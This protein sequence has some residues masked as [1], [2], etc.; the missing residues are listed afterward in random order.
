MKT[1]HLVALST[2]IGIA[3]AGVGM[4]DQA[5]MISSAQAGEA[6]SAP[7]VATDGVYIITYR[8]AGLLNYQGGVSGL[9]RTAPDSAAGQKLDRNSVAAHGYEAWLE[10]QRGVHRAE[11]ESAIGRVIRASHSYG[12]TFNGIAVELTPDEAAKVAALP[13]VES[14]RP[15]GVYHLG[16]YRGPK[17]I[18]AAQV[19]DG[20]STPS[21]VG[22]RGQGVKVGIID[23]GANSAHP[24]FANDATCGFS[25]SLPKLTAK[26]CSS[27]SG[28]ICN[29]ANPQ[30]NATYGHG[31]HTGSTVAGNTIDNTVTPAPSLPNGVTMS[32]VAPCAQVF[33]YKV[34]PTDSC[35]GADIQA[36]IDNAIADGVD[37][38]NFSISGGT[39]PWTDNDR[40]FLDAVGAGVFVAAA[41][42]NTS[43]SVTNP[44]GQVNHRGPWV[45]TVAATT[46][47]QIIGPGFSLTGP[48]TPP[49]L[50]QNVA[51]NPGSTTTASSTPTWTGKPVKTWPTNI[52]ACTASGGIPAGTFTGAI[53]VVRRGTCTFTEKITNAFNAGA[54]LVVIGN[55]Q[56]GSINMDTTGAPNVPAYS[57]SQAS[58]DA[59]IAFVGSN[60]SNSTADVAPIVVASRQG[61]VLANFSFRGPTPA[62]LADL[63]KPDISGPGVDIYAA[64]DPAS[65]QYQF[66][67]GT[68]M[69]TPHVA[70]AGALVKAVHPT[71][72]PVEIRS[73]LMMTAKPDGFREDGTTPWDV[74]DVGSGRVNVAAAAMAGLTMNETK[75]NFLAANP[76]GGSINVKQLNVPSLRNM[77]CAG[78][79]SW[80]RTVK[81]RMAASGNWTVTTTTD[82]SFSVSASPASFTLAANAEQ[83][84]TFTATPSTNITAVKFGYITLTEG[85]SAS[86]AQ[87]LTVAIKGT[88]GA[89]YTVGGSVSGLTGTGLVLK[90]NGANNLSVNANGSFTFPGGL[91]GGA[92]YAVTVGTQPSGQ[93]CSV[94]NGS[95]TIASTNVTNVAVTCAVASNYT[96]GGAVSGLTAAGLKLSLNTGAQLLDVPA[97]ATSYVFANP[98]ID[99]S[100]YNV[101]IVTQP[102]GL[103]CS[104]S[105]HSGTL[106]GANVTNVNISCVPTVVSYTV[107]G[108]IIGL[109]ANGLVLS[110]NAG[111]QTIAITSG[112]TAFTFPTGLANGAAYAVAV[113]TQPSGL[114]C[115]ATS[116]S[117]TIAGANVTNVVIDCTDRIFA[118]GFESP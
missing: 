108:S 102:T 49:V 63:T 55:N 13:S 52:E 91:A 40:K 99:G 64:T 28:G 39:S 27:S 73:A 41:A 109:S 103:T 72:S 80:T 18:G 101:G 85:S 71:W 56:A 51:L 116:S 20:T 44:V 97:N 67:S 62:P 79:C 96:I 26:D 74:D 8:E 30:A 53:A 84:I 19:W 65:G 14:V 117:G 12:I 11:I 31:V 16:T 34:C 89:T 57:T 1:L 24:S 10:T 21:H 25:V 22:T 54:E 82:P 90:L 23:G 93:T 106:A 46:Q 3:L 59:V 9:A 5:R 95:G 47:D 113:Q 68:S 76:S 81:N 4:G 104:V 43:A 69:A 88:S 86:P 75:A 35:P 32:G 2:A 111:A 48:G 98:I 45:M 6:V 37:A 38:I 83:T 114:I 36:G 17:F 100:A 87:H 92:S 50:T 61:D 110:L 66:M 29:G 58:G 115:A 7:E 42:G 70:G 78:S 105:N 15:A 77:A 60:P 33:Q 118:N 107:G 94:A 112:V